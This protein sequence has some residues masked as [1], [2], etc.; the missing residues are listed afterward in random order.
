MNGDRAGTVGRKMH[1]RTIM[2]LLA[3]TLAVLVLLTFASATTS[4]RLEAT[5]SSLLNEQP[6]AIAEYGNVKELE[7][8]VIRL[9]ATLSR[10][11]SSVNPA[12]KEAFDRE[13]IEAVSLLKGIQSGNVRPVLLVEAFNVW[14]DAA[15]KSFHL[16]AALP[17]AEE[18]RQALSRELN[19]F[20][21]ETLSRLEAERH[22]SARYLENAAGVQFGVLVLS[23]LLSLVGAYVLRRVLVTPL[24]SLIKSTR[25]LA[26]EG[27]GVDLDRNFMLRDLMD[28]QEALRVFHNNAVERQEL[29]RVQMR[30]AEIK[31][32]RAQ[33]INR[34][35]ESFD[36]HVQL[37][38]AQLAETSAT[39]TKGSFTLSETSRVA[40]AE[41]NDA[42]RIAEELSGAV[43]MLMCGSEEVEASVHEISRSADL[44]QA[45]SGAA[46]KQAQ[47]MKESMNELR[48]LASAIDKILEIIKGM[49]SQTNLLALNATIEAARAGEVGKGFAVVATE[50]KK[51]A[52]QSANAADEIAQKI[53]AIQNASEHTMRAIENVDSI[54]CDSSKYAISVASAVAQQSAA[55]STMTRGLAEIASA[56]QSSAAGVNRVRNA[57]R[58]T[59]D[60]AQLVQ[61][62][63]VAVS[64]ESGRLRDE[65]S[66][67][68]AGVRAA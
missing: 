23:L 58:T 27:S 63:A 50:V 29:V 21:G 17:V 48:Q 38:L 19:S 12:D 47:Q 44:S 15:H 5:A 60:I 40:L 16:M 18:A 36:S 10:Y 9:E 30:E 46:V 6:R 28:M 52:G 62:H 34:L 49:A 57:V 33:S 37:A 8:R 22:A 20:L 42:D 25:Q 65:I 56:S 53:T 54:V 45:A 64:H 66:R 35:T 3:G 32:L 11:I 39:L 7:V 13:L 59:E 51:L 1:R 24:Q 61:E 67:F 55:I 68:A 31:N 4:L 2:G 43:T 14:V 41:V 26:A